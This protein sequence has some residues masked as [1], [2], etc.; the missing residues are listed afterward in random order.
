MD[1]NQARKKLD[2]CRDLFKKGLYSPESWIS[3]PFELRPLSNGD[4]LAIRPQLPAE[5]ILLKADDDTPVPF[6]G[7]L[8]S[9]VPGFGLPLTREF[10]LGSA[11]RGRYQFY[12]RG[13]AIWEQFQNSNNLGYP[14]AS[15]KSP[16]E[17]VKKCRA[18]VAFFDLRGFTKW[19]SSGATPKQI[20]EAVWKFEVAF[21]EAFSSKWCEYL[22]TKG[23]GDGFMVVSEE[24]WYVPAKPVN[25]TGGHGKEFFRACA[26]TILNARNDSLPEELAIGCG[27][28]IGE[29][30]QLYIL[31]RPDYTGPAVNN[32]SKIQ[33]KA[34]DEICTTTE[35]LDCLK[36]DGIVFT[37]KSL[38]DN[39]IRITPEN[40][41]SA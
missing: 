23:T 1:E 36:A 20:Q 39:I 27:I 6:F 17:R 12:E 2:K 22:F 21:Q 18:L 14:V 32:A 35:V 19:S 10:L 30:T 28:T 41:L 9:L 40:V 38:P 13:L 11:R 33:S 34:Y 8:G 15:W 7:A 25:F 29:I 5:G 3:D 26:T 24:G 37:G 31:G 16:E 4:W